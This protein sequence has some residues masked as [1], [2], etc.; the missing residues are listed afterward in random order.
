MMYVHGDDDGDEDDGGDDDV[1]DDGAFVGD[2]DGHD[3]WSWKEFDVRACAW[4]AWSYWIMIDATDKFDNRARAR[5][6]KAPFDRNVEKPLVRWF[7]RFLKGARA[8]EQIFRR[9]R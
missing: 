6:A 8:G 7:V 3:Q 9:P 2:G 5:P 1:D 4:P